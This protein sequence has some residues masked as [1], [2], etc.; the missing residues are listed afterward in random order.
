MSTIK[1]SE[2]AT[3]AISLTDFFAKADSAGLANKNTVQGLSN[4]LNTVGTLAFRGVLLAADAA[5]TL[6]GIYVAGDSGT[7]TNNGGLVIDVSN[8]I[9]LISITGTQTVFEKVEIPV[10][11]VKD[12][13]PTEGSANPVESGGVSKFIKVV[14]NNIFEKEKNI[15]NKLLNTGEVGF[16]QNIFTAGTTSEISNPSDSPFTSDILPTIYRFTGNGAGDYKIQFSQSI[17]GAGATTFSFWTKKS[18][19][20]LTGLSYFA[21]YDGGWRNIAIPTIVEQETSIPYH[22]TTTAKRVF[23]YDDWVMFQFNF[24]N[25][26][27]GTFWIRFATNFAGTMDFAN[28]IATD[29]VIDVSPYLVSFKLKAGTFTKRIKELESRVSTI[30]N[31]NVIVCYGDSLTAATYPSDL[32]SLIGSNYNVVNRGV[33]G[34]PTHMIS[35]RQGGDPM[36][37]S[38]LVIPASTSPVIVGYE[39]ATGIRSMSAGGYIQPLRLDPTLAGINP[40]YIDGIQGNLSYNGTDY[41]FNREVAGTERTTGSKAIIHTQNMRDYKR[42]ICAVIFMG[43]NGTFS[44]AESLVTQFNRMINY[45]DNDNF[46]VITTHG[47]GSTASIIDAFEQNYGGRY[48]NLREYMSTHAIYDAG[49]TPTQSDLDAMALGNCPPQLLVDS[50]HFTSVGYNL[51]AKQVQQKLLELGYI[52]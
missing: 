16:P 33:G 3:S 30:E 32:Q 36:Y 44:S 52:K 2:L 6:D 10:S 1:I 35:A 12:A 42:P 9:V 41:R 50:L 38:N 49:L 23:E 4:F 26:V 11:I 27:F 18:Q 40:C 25:Y 8:Q 13:T 19:L 20:A 15:T 14:G 46:I 43:Q 34:E 51:L 31:N 24:T 48:I 17:I 7:Y 28:L 39:V 29:E 37:V 45:L 22:G 21:V 5:V 47:T